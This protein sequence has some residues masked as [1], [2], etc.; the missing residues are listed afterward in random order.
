MQAHYFL[1]QGGEEAPGQQAL[2][3]EQGFQVTAETIG[4]GPQ[5]AQLALVALDVELRRVQTVQRIL[6]VVPLVDGTDHLVGQCGLVLQGGQV[7]APQGLLR[8]GRP[9][10]RAR[11]GPG[12]GSARPT[13]GEDRCGEEGDCG[14]CESGHGG[15]TRGKGPAAPADHTLDRP[16]AGLR[17][18]GRIGRC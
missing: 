4:L 7:D 1:G 14:A 18:D 5:L 17:L 9:G 11:R 12:A 16:G 13:G 3:G 15:G 8:R 2:L 10:L 6:G